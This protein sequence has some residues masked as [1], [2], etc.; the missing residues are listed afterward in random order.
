[1]SALSAATTF[2][3]TDIEGS[4]RLWEQEPERMSSALARHD[5]IARAAVESHGGLVVKTTGDGVHA[6]FDDPLDAIAA[7]LELQ[8]RLADRDATCG[9][10]LP[11]RCGLHL[12]IAERRNNEFFGTP[13][14]RAA[15]L[16]AA[17]HGGQVLLSQ[18]VA[19]PIADRLRN[20][21]TLRDLGMV[22]LRD[23]ANPEHVF[24]LVHPQ[25]RAEFPALRSLEATPN[26]LPQQITSFI[27]REQELTEVKRLLAGARLLTL[28]GAGGVGK[29]RLALQAAADVIDD[30]PDGVWFVSLAPIN[31]P[32]LVPNTV[33]QTLKV[34]QDNSESLTHTL[35]SYL[36]PLRLLLILDNCE[37]LIDACAHLTEPLLR[38][39]LHLRILTTSREALRVAGEQTY[40]LP[41][42]SLPDAKGTPDSISRSDAVQLFVERG[43][44][45]QQGFAL[46]AERAP[47]IAELCIRL[48]GIPLALELAAARIEVLPVEKIV[49]RLD[50]RFRLLTGGSRTALPRQQ[51]LR[52]LIT[53]SFDLL[54]EVEKKFFARLSVFAG[55]L[56]LEAAEAIG[57]GDGIPQEDVLALLSSLVDKSLVLV[58]ENG[59]RY[60]LLETMRQFAQERLRAVGDEPA[61][62]ERH[63]M[64]Y[65]AVVQRAE[66]EMEGGAEQ[67][68]A[69]DM[70]EADHDNLR[71][72]L[73]WAVET[74]ERA[75]SAVKMCA[76]A[77]GLWLFR[78]YWE[79][80]YAWCMKALVQ[81]P[82]GGDKAAR[83]RTLFAAGTLLDKRPLLEEALSLS[84]EAGD[85]QTEAATLNDLGRLLMHGGVEVSLAQSLVEEARMINREMGNQV[86]EL[87]NVTILTLGCRLQGNSTVARVLAEEGLARS[88]SLKYRRLEASFL[89]LLAAVARDR[90]DVGAAQTLYAESLAIYRELGLPLWQ[91]NKMSELAALAIIRG[92]A[93]SA[94]SHLTE[95]L[96]I[97]RKIGERGLELA[98]SFDVIGALASQAQQYIEAARFSGVADTLRGSA[99]PSDPFHREHVVLYRA[100]GRETLGDAAYDTAYKAGCALKRETAI[101]EAL[102]WLA[103]A[104]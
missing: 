55:G 71:S 102:A 47:A 89:G 40:R 1:V 78:G 34:K 73:T 67:T 46:T 9:L 24:Q 66:P 52:A 38:A 53:W 92:D 98:P 69:L 56:T 82:S 99:L 31:D 90:S 12:G 86:W 43:R 59:Q 22:R 14:N 95:A 15:R 101:N 97:Y 26:N 42:L 104:H 44:L 19:S 80:G 11:V 100:Q 7:S 57:A 39:A 36:N 21:V 32:I 77:Y 5:A 87:E 63:F 35:C 17:A 48:D 62:R 28:R 88:R 2:L 79:E 45:Q 85:R 76:K 16:M 50:D 8:H 54:S 51:T 74:P 6:A 27:G 81:A 37:H 91:A 84:R 65:L 23:L 13:V 10:A 30:Y 49:E 58:D 41:S 70:L 68:R 83:A 18:A 60:R 94:G 33:A 3:F 72:A 61:I 103:S 4:T 29:T 64:Y 75:E 96:D 25:L 20:D 93:S